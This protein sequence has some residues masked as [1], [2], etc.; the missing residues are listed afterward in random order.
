[1]YEQIFDGEWASAFFIL[2]GISLVLA[3]TGAV[4]VLFEPSAA[5]SGIPEVLAF[6]NGS[7]L[8]RPLTLRTLL[9]KVFGLIA[10]VAAGL[11]IGPEGPMIMCGATLA[12]VLVNDLRFVPWLSRVFT[13]DVELGKVFRGRLRSKQSSTY[14]ESTSA[15]SENQ[16]FTVHN[17]RDLRVFSLAGAAAGVAAAFHAPIGG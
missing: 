7:M 10:A 4:A 5:G 16:V 17:D 6:L 3:L 14:E 8:N 13:G 12:I 15:T 1:M 2:S 9:V 11:A